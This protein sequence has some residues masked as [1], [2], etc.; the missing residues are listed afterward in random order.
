MDFKTD[1]LGLLAFRN[2]GLKGNLLAD[3]LSGLVKQIRYESDA[4]TT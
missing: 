4:V 1:I 3:M 2:M